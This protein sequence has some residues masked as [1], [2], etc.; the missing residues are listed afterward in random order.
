MLG[1]V[2]FALHGRLPVA[3]GGP[4]PATALCVFLLV[5]SVGADLAGRMPPQDI[6]LTMVMGLALC[7][8]VSGVAGVVVMPLARMLRRSAAP[9]SELSGMLM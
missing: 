7:G 9:S 2:L 8:A 4:D 5:A 3:V 6:S 1:S